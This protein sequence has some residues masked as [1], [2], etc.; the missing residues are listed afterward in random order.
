MR[1][2]LKPTGSLYLH[3]DPTASHYIKAL[4][5]AIF[6]HDNFQSEITWKRTSAHSDAKGFGQVRDVILYYSKSSHRTWNR[7]VIDHD[8]SYVSRNYRYHDSKGRY[9]F[10]EI[11]R[12]ASMGERPNLAYE[13]KGLYSRMG[14]A[15][16]TPQIG[17]TRC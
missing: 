9:R 15:H 11:I 12:T 7:I 16:G 10:H 17:G 14:L 4:M 6:G 2:I 5:D 8:S 13:Y 1:R 3:C